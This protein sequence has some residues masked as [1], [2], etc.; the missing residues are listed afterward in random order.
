MK[1]DILIIG[2]GIAGLSAAAALAPHASVTLLEAEDALGYHASGRSA[3]MFLKDYGNDVVRA[4]N[5]A[6]ADHHESAGILTPR[7]MMMFAR[8]HERDDFVAEAAHF[9]M[10]EISM[11]QARTHVPILKPD[12]CAYAAYRAD[13]HDL[14]AD[15]LLQS[16]TAQARR[17]GVNIVQKSRVSAIAKTADRWQVQAGEE[18]YHANI[19]INAAG[20]WVDEIARLAGIAPLGFQPY[21]RSM[22][23][24]PAP[25]GHDV[26]TW[27]FLDG[28]NER[29]YAKPDAGKWIVSP[30]D[31]DPVEPHDA[32]ADDMVL[33][34]GLARYEEMVTEA[35]TRLETSWAGLRTFSPDR[36]LVI[37]AD[38]SDPTF[39]W[40]GGQGGYGFQTAPAASRLIADLVT[41]QS[42]EIGADI[43]T[44]LSPSRF[45]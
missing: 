14:D 22:A 35:V 38:V 18:T 17:D 2:G 43:A 10:Q 42:P 30:S 19:L 11:D 3:A 41:G 21:R 33:A 32:W 20:A 23:R 44:A 40:L 4:L 5:Y 39:Y 25:G 1:T 27:P 8:P 37:G 13:A 34:E 31:E 7:G 15:R 29:W 9:N 36:A 12:T 6:S 16:Y 24:I 26:S 45:S 28:V